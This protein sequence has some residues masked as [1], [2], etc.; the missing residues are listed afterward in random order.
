MSMGPVWGA[1]LIAV[2]AGATPPVATLRDL[3]P[4]LT[5]CFKAPDRST[6]SEVTV[7]LSLTRDGAVL[8]KPRITFSKLV[9]EPEDKRAF[10][11]AVLGSLSACTPVA[12]L[13]SFGGAIAGRPL[14]LRF[15]GGGPAKAI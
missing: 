11:A 8:G 13:P 14:T 12:L 3:G 6:G 4:A 10:V 15:I 5:H 2:A 1:V 9:G 7:L